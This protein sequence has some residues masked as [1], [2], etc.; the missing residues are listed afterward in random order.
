MRSSAE[1]TAKPNICKEQ[2]FL[3]SLGSDSGMISIPPTDD[4]CMFIQK[5]RETMKATVIGGEADGQTFESD[6]FD[7]HPTIRLYKKGERKIL[8][9]EDFSVIDIA[10]STYRR[11]WLISTGIRFCIYIEIS[12]STD[13][14]LQMLLD[15]YEQKGKQ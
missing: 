7:N 6:S 8:T 9:G 2:L 14:A 15:W 11:E 5:E 12:T 10:V 13:D 1:A 3:R 4:R